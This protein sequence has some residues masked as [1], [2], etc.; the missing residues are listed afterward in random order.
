MI[1]LYLEILLLGFIHDANLRVVKLSQVTLIISLQTYKILVC[2][3]TKVHIPCSPDTQYTRVGYGGMSD[4]PMD[5]LETFKPNVDGT[6]SRIPKAL[7]CSLSN[8]R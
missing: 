1:V 4:A 6:K 5:G 2:D 8:I 7:R 3:A